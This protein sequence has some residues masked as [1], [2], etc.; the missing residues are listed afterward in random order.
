MATATS[1]WDP[2]AR[3]RPSSSTSAATTAPTSSLVMRATTYWEAGSGS[4]LFSAR[5]GRMCCGGGNDTV[6]D[7][8]DGGYGDNLLCVADGEDVMLGATAPDN[9]TTVRLYVS[10]ST[11]NPVSPDTRANSTDSECG[12]AVVGPWSQVGCT[13]VTLTSPPGECAV[14]GVPQ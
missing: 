12:N 9:D 7:T 6:V 5:L 2:T 4:T 8:L 1:S 13:Q 14:L 3:A 11:P 10:Q